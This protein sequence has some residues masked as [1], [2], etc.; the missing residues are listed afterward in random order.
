[1]K[2]NQLKV[3][4]KVSTMF[5]R[6]L[7]EHRPHK[8]KAISNNNTTT[9]DMDMIVPPHLHLITSNHGPI[10]RIYNKKG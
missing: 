7:D 8:H 4:L 6:R 3:S 9:K 5:H 1:M 2:V 10:H